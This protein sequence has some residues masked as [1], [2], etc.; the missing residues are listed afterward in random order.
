MCCS[1][2]NKVS[3]V[4]YSFNIQALYQNILMILTGII[5]FQSNSSFCLYISFVSLDS[6][7]SYNFL[8]LSS[9]LVPCDIVATGTQSRLDLSELEGI[10]AAS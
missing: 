9:S 10:L 7:V 6:H 3:Y 4:F 5:V 8:G 1:I 2:K